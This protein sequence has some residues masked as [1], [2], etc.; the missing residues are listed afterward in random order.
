MNL[1]CRLYFPTAQKEIHIV[2]FEIKRNN[3]QFLHVYKFHLK[4]D[5]NIY[6]LNTFTFNK[7]YTTNNTFRTTT[8]EIVKGTHVF[9][10]IIQ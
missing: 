1:I 2:V 5:N 10:I 3:F 9:Y 6:E 4:K 8:K 7:Q